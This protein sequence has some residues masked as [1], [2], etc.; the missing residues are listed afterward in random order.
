[1]P[2]ISA[3]FVDEVSKQLTPGKFAVV[4]EIEEEQTAA[5]DLS[6]EGLGGVVYR[7][8]FLT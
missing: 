8:L 4:A 6:M 3:D 2:R 1:M 5:V 7:A